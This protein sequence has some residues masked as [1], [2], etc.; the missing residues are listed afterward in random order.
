[1]VPICHSNCAPTIESDRGEELLTC[2]N[3]QDH[4][5]PGRR[6]DFLGLVLGIRRVTLSGW[7]LRQ[8]FGVRLELALGCWD[9]LK[10]NLH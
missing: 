9:G 7:S 2:P 4:V 6:A 3:V 10:L 8:L 1:M 5:G